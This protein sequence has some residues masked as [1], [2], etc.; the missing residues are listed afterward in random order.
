MQKGQSAIQQRLSRQYDRLWFRALKQIRAGSIDIDPVLRRRIPDE[1][2]GLT[3]IARPSHSVR[4]AVVRFLSELRRLEPHQYYYNASEF[5]LTILSLFTAT[6]DSDRFFAARERY[7]AAVD[8]ALERVGP[9]RIRFNGITASPASVMVQGFFDTNDLRDVRNR[10]RRQLRIS[11]LGRG[12][13]QRYRLQ[14]AHMT[15]V[16]FRAPLRRPSR[17]AK[18][19]EEARRRAF[20]V[21]DVTG[22]SLVENDWYMSRRATCCLKRYR[23]KSSRGQG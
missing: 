15:V 13:D 8:A 2:R 1:R 18:A 19:L 3:V 10:L 12:L 21:T 20:G 4:H 9:L 14:T 7:A 16:R 11:G 6:I 5:H 23:L 17:F 22:L